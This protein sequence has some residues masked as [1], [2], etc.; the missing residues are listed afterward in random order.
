MIGTGM[1]A[2]LTEARLSPPPIRDANR[3]VVR[4]NVP[5]LDAH[6]HLDKGTVDRPL[7]ELIA[8]NSNDRAVRGN[9]ALITIGH[10]DPDM[11]E[12][13][14]PPI[15]GYVAEFKLGSYLGNPCLL[16][17]LHIRRDRVDQAMTFPHR[18]VE[19]M[20]GRLETSNYIDSI[21][22]L[23]TPPERPLGLITYGRSA[24]E[25]PRRHPATETA[26]MMTTMASLNDLTRHHLRSLEANRGRLD[27][28]AADQ[29]TMRIR[30]NRRARRPQIEA[31]KAAG[32]QLDPAEELKRVERMTDQEFARHVG[33]IR[34]RYSRTDDAATGKTGS[35]PAAG[36]MPPPMPRPWRTPATSSP[37]HARSRSRRRG[38]KTPCSDS[39]RLTT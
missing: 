4:K 8:K 36:G 29:H 17:D 22:L 3:F 11:P 12:V 13:H 30:Y 37:T 19:R 25:I 15:V 9:Y 26:T 27:R 21:A 18:S 38:T 28:I 39:G 33:L 6:D 34:T 35:P 23:R 10:T 5:I 1:T 24:P 20:S 32:Y 31:L 7:L 14:Q 2:T 16:A